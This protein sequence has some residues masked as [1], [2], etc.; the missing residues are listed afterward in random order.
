MAP[1]P[2]YAAPVRSIEREVVR[3][4]GDTQSITHDRMVVEEP[5]ELRIDETPIAVV[6]RTPGDDSD[7]ALGFALTEGILLEPAELEALVPVGEN[8]LR[9]NTSRQVDAERFRRNLYTSSSCGV[10]GKGSIDAVRMTMPEY[11]KRPAIA[12]NVLV[13]LPRRMRARQRTFAET[14]GLHAAA[15]FALDGS[16]RAV[17]EDIGR[18]NAVD[19]VIGAVA[20]DVWPLTSLV[21]MVSGRIS[22]EIVQKAAM[23]GIP[24][25]AGVSAA[26]SL[27]V[28]LGSELG[29]TIVGFLR[30]ET[31]NLYAGR[32]VEVSA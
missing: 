3:F 25:V 24:C 28:E 4:D 10:C 12:R 23:V 7:L 20:Q 2:H 13:E 1:F 8:R 31:F 30:E 27:A 18:H 9:L 17:R 26:S 14:G 6:M 15:L 19:K 22:F 5:L 16:L 21:L 32:L 11:S 29:M